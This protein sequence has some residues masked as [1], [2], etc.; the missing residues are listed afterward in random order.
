MSHIRR[1]VLIG[2]MA[3][4]A[5]G[6]SADE[7]GHAAAPYLFAVVGVCALWIAWDVFRPKWVQWRASRR[8]GGYL[9]IVGGFKSD[10]R[11]IVRYADGSQDT[12]IYATAAGTTTLTGIAAGTWSMPSRW[13]RLKQRLRRLRGV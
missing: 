12:D 2:V 4:A 9:K 7:W 5:V 11:R 8:E 3:A 13:D 1:E 10:R 6:A